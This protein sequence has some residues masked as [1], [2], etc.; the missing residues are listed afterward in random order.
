MG[1]DMGLQ[2]SLHTN[3]TGNQVR[4]S[5]TGLGG[6]KTAQLSSQ[7]TTYKCLL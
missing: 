3:K 6:Y 4:S 5:D 2:Y 7:S 1:R